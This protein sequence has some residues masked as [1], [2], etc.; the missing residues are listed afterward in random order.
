MALQM[1]QMGRQMTW[2]HD[3]RA[4]VLRYAVVNS[5]ATCRSLGGARTGT[6][7]DRQWGLMRRQFCTVA[8][9]KPIHVV[10]RMPGRRACNHCNRGKTHYVCCG[11]GKWYHVRCFAVAH[12]V[13]GVVEVDVEEESQEAEEDGS[14]REEGEDDEEE[15]SEEEGEE[16]EDKESEEEEESEE[17]EDEDMEEDEA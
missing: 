1:H 10:V 12:G 2:S 8:V 6:M 14:E 13:T 5:Y 4:F 7:F 9:P 3:V 16:D 17:G 11:C 15:E